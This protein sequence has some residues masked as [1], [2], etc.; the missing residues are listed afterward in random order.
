MPLAG[1]ESGATGSGI[2]P[3]G[4]RGGHNA[5]TPYPGV[6]A[7]V[8]RG[9]PAVAPRLPAAGGPN[10]SGVGLLPPVNGGRQQQQ[11]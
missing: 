8:G 4:A 10:G 2:S 3:S 6:G 11:R 7:A 5:R 9:G 1:W